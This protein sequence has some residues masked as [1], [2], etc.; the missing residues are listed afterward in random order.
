MSKFVEVE[1]LAFVQE[2]DKAALFLVKQG[3]PK[4]PDDADEEVWIPFSH[5]E[6]RMVKLERGK[7]IRLSVTRW[8]AEQKGLEYI[9]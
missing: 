3:D 5:F 9:E 7:P 1:F 6:N 2:S 4:D 8:I